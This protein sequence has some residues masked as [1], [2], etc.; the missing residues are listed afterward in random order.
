MVSSLESRLTLEGLRQL[1]R[2]GT[3][4]SRYGFTT[5]IK[6]RVYRLERTGSALRTTMLA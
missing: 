6:K 5:S 1:E 2:Q 4:K 3:V